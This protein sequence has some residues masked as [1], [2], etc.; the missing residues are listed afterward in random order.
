M[1][2]GLKTKLQMKVSE[3]IKKL[4][5]MLL[6]LCS[7]SV[8]SAGAQS[9]DEPRPPRRRPEGRPQGQHYHYHLNNFRYYGPGPYCPPRFVRPYGFYNYGY[10]GPRRGSEVYFR[11]GGPPRRQAGFGIGF[12]NFGW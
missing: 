1:D 7:L 2:V 5:L 10:Y 9:H 3:M 11:F 4:S 8:L 12:S 6:V